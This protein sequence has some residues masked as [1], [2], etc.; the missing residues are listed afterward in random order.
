[1]KKKQTALW[2]I[3]LILLL[4]LIPFIVPSSLSVAGAESVDL[5]VFE[6][7][8]LSNPNPGP[9]PTEQVPWTNSSAM[10]EKVCDRIDGGPPG[11]S[12]HGIFQAR[13]LEWGAI[14]FSVNVTK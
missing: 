13:V 11:S 9:V 12:I 1:M 8:V 5:P 14:A 4:L 6:P 2:L 3:P 10:R 7:V